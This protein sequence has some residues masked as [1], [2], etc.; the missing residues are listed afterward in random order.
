MPLLTPRSHP[1]AARAF[2][3]IELLTVI[4]IVGVLA[5]ILVPTVGSV[6]EA[7]RSS[8][9]QS[10]LRQTGMAFNLYAQNN[11]G[12]YPAPRFA[13]TNNPSANPNPTG[14]NWQLEV[15]PYISPKLQTGAENPF[16]L[17]E[18]VAELNIAYCPSY[19]VLFG[20]SNTAAQATNLNALGYGMNINLNVDGKDINFGGRIVKRF[21][22]LQIVNPA[23]QIMIGD[24]ADWMIGVE[25]TRFTPQTDAA[26]PEGYR[27]G[28]PT[29]H[30]G[31]ANYLYADGHVETQSPE[32]ALQLLQFRA[33]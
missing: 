4:A 6:R 30:R 17:K 20:S 1:G 8:T 19:W 26:H 9:C 23:R 21:P 7:A 16:R 13:D 24:S 18:K 2:T 5:A 32:D 10:N 3:L 28:A 31:K 14:W 29:R 15:A 33:L 25:A 22:A 27:S 11:R 12:V